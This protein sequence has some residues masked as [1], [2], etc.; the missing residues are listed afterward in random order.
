MVAPVWEATVNDNDRAGSSTTSEDATSTTT[1]DVQIA[2]QLTVEEGAHRLERSWSSLLATGAVGG[3]DVTVGVFGLMVV[4]HLTD[5]KLLGSLVFTV[6]FIAL[7]LARSELFTENFLV[8]L[9]TVVAGRKGPGSVLRLWGGTAVANLAG[10][11]IFAAIL[12]AGFPELHATAVQLGMH[13]VEIG[14]GW[15][16]FAMA[17]T[18][19]AIITIMTWMIEGTD[20]AGAQIVAAIVAGFLLTA[21]E[22]NHCIVA[23]LEMFA[24]LV[25]GA[26]FGYLDWFTVFVWAVLG[27]TVGGIG[28]VTV[29]RFV[30][31]GTE[32]VN[33]E[34]SE[35]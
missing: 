2:F 30:Q 17:M 26:P 8:P 9:S 14:I 28:F 22:M 11:W 19:G 15:R 32:A 18:T 21:G 31:V 10:G 24:A 6:G 12:M 25:A 29:L 1:E 33:A 34:R 27:N 5:S 7:T 20:S 3:I 23:S 4:Q 13:F 35:R 16:S